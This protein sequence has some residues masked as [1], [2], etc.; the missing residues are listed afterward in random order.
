MAITHIETIKKLEVLTANNDNIV[1]KVTVNIS[2]SDDSN[3]SKYYFNGS[4]T[5]DVSTT[6][7]TTSTSG[8]VAYEDLTESTVKGWISAGISTCET[9]AINIVMINQM[10]AKD[11]RTTTDKTI[12][13]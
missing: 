6:G 13:W 4:E 8:F 3:P 10:I 11:N 12:P 5:L 1:G 2:S 9:R 7:I